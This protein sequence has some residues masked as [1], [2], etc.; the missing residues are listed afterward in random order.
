MKWEKKLKNMVIVVNW[1]EWLMVILVMLLSTWVLILSS[2]K[3]LD[4]TAW[5]PGKVE[6]VIKRKK[7]KD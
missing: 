2:K 3:E 5:I 6:L 4:F 7:S 1:T